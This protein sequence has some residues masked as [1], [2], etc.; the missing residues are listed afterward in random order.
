MSDTPLFDAV[1]RY[2]GAAATRCHTPGHGGKSAVLADFAAVLPFDVTEVAG[3]DS[4]YE[5]DGVIA[6]AEQKTAALFGADRTL[7]SAGGCT[8][9]IQTMLALAAPSGGRVAMGRNLHRSAVNAAALLDIAPVWLYPEPEGVVTPA[10]VEEALEAYPDLRAVYLTSPNYYGQLCDIGAISAL[11]RRSGVPLLVDNAHGSH[12]AFFTPSL[13]PLALGADMAA[14]SA[15]KTLPVLTGGA[16]LQIGNPV[17]SD[18]AKSVMS[19]F[20][21]TSPS[22]L[23]MGSLDLCRAWLETSGKAAFGCLQTR[24]EKI[25]SAAKELGLRLPGGVCD[26][27]RVTL[28]TSAIGLPGSAAAEALRRFQVEPEY[29][30]TKYVILLLNPF[31]DDND[32]SRILEGIGH[33]PQMQRDENGESVALPTLPRPEASLS[34]RQALLAPWKT[35]EVPSAAGKIAAEAVCPCPPGIPAVIPGERIDGDVL[36][37]LKRYGILRIKVIK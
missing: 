33:L 23:V 3:L 21:S 26:P 30:D 1:K 14:C 19:V 15:H 27:V 13:H 6:A 16:W 22:Y 18:R 4:L 17:F 8:L 20:G 28:D 5:A 12:L 25:K 37:F 11:C 29:A 34:P 7:F 36:D 9:A 31:Q 2:A 35:T 32:F 24:A 10:A